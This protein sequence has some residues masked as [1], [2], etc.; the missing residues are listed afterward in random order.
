M[1][2]LLAASQL[3]GPARAASES[4]DDVVKH[5]LAEVLPVSCIK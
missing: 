4:D 5:C 2:G 1:A 3:A